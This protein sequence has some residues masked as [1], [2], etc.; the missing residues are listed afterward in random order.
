MTIWRVGDL[1]LTRN[2]QKLVVASQDGVYIFVYSTYKNQD[3]NEPIQK[4]CRHSKPTTFYHPIEIVEID[5]DDE[6]FKLEFI[7]V[8][9][10]T[11]AAYLFKM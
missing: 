10:S 8:S 7:V 4:F 2:S 11:G 9:S 3:N 5:A 6:N 1:K